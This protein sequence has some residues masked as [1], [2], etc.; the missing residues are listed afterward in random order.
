MGMKET[1]T[2]FSS[3]EMWGRSIHSLHG[4]CI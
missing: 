4:G 1:E 3:F 2:D